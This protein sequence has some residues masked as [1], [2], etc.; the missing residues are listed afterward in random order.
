MAKPRQ[1]TSREM[2]ERLKI[3][4]KQMTVVATAIAFLSRGLR[5]DAANEVAKIL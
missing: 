4:E 3:L 5:D 2:Y 1:I